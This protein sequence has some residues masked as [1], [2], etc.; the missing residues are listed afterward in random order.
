VSDDPVKYLRGAFIGY[1]P[2]GYPDGPKRVIPFRFNPETLSRSLQVQQGRSGS[3]TEGASR[4]GGGRSDQG[5]DASSGT[6]K[7]TLS[8]QVRF[9]FHDRHDT[10]QDLPAELGIAPEIAALESLLYPAESPSEHTGDGSEP[11]RAR[12]QRPTVLFVWGRKR[13]LPVRITGMK[14]NETLF[15]TELNP[16]RAEVEVS[17]EVLGETD[18]KDN[19]AV[20][21]ALSFTGSKRRELAKQFYD[22]T[23]SQGTNILPL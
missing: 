11:V 20:S 17:L 18:A 10:A 8:V 21:D 5:A 2:G 12:S 16:L 15:N 13:V 23:A 22:T 1:E 14:V 4:G 3:G 9:D 6:L 19:R 7:Q